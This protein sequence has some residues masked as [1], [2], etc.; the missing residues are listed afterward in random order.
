MSPFKLLVWTPIQEYISSIEINCRIVW[1]FIYGHIKILLC[2][3][4]SVDM[5]VSKS[6]II[7][8]DAWFLNLDGFSIMNKSFFELTLLEVRETQV[9]MN[10]WPIILHF[11]SFLQ[12]LN[13]LI[14]VLWSKSSKTDTLVESGLILMILL[15]YVL[16]CFC[17]IINGFFYFVQ[18]RLNQTAII[19]VLPILVIVLDCLV[20]ML[21][22][23]I[24]LAEF[25][26]LDTGH[27]VVLS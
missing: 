3:L 6:S 1:V 18:S 27:A 2:L 4:Q 5:I 13:W 8:M 26:M 15:W 24:E 25:I 16:K 20:I 22:C 19:K 23:L 11:H 10:T 17:I 21:E 14:K 9:V 12:I 7:I